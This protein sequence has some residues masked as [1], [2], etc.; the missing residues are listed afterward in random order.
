MPV[1]AYDVRGLTVI[2]WAEAKR[3]T[4]TFLDA[5][6]D[7]A[8]AVLSA[9]WINDLTAVAVNHLDLQSLEEDL[10]QLEGGLVELVGV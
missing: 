1:V 6:C 2:T 8:Y 5:Y 7:E 10:K 4:W 9:D 3:M